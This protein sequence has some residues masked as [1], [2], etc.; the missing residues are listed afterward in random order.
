MIFSFGK[1]K[2][3]LVQFSRSMPFFVVYIPKFDHN[4]FLSFLI[5]GIILAY[6]HKF[7]KKTGKA[8][9]NRLKQTLKGERIRTALNGLIL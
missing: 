9:K 4:K 8:A 2:T 6:S 7:V 1:R 5:C 3:A